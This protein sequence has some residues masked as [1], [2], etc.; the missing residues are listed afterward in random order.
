MAA[1]TA[2][3]L[4][5]ERLVAT[6]FTPRRPSSR[7]ISAISTPPAPVSTA[8]CPDRLNM[9]SFCMGQHASRRPALVKLTRLR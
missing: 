6:T 2:S 7:A 3:A 9:E 8:T 5:S 1:A 4:A